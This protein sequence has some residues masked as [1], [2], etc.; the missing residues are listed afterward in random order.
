MARTRE[1]TDN[2]TAL[3]KT[4]REKMAQGE[5]VI[6]AMRVFIQDKKIYDLN[7]YRSTASEIFKMLDDIKNQEIDADAK[8]DF[9]SF[10]PYYA[11]FAYDKA[12]GKAI[13]IICDFIRDCVLKKRKAMPDVALKYYNFLKALDLLKMAFDVDDFIE[14]TSGYQPSQKDAPLYYAIECATGMKENAEHY[15]NQFNNII[16]EYKSNTKILTIKENFKSKILRLVE[17]YRIPF[18]NKE[19]EDN[20]LAGKIIKYFGLKENEA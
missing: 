7:N 17:I 3:T 12:K 6:E 4:Q 2:G 9:D 20:I 13:E 18:N 1:T 19:T 14:D 5:A 10:A 8:F 16:N 15:F 11:F